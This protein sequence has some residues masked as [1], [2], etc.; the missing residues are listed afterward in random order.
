MSFEAAA[1]SGSSDGPYIPDAAECMRCGMCVSSC[2]TFRLFEIDEETPRR[3]IRSIGKVLLENQP[4]DVEEQAHLDN[5]LQ[6]RS[7]ETVCPSRMAYGNLF[8]QAQAKIKLD[9]PLN[10]QARLAFWLV[11]HK[12]WRNSLLPLLSLYLRSG[13]QRPL[14]AS[15]LLKKIKLATAEAMLNEPSLV[16]LSGIYP[17]SQ[18]K[19]RGRVALFTGCLAENFD[20]AT[21]RASIKLLNAIGYEVVVPEGQGCCGAIHQHNGQSAQK[22]IDNNIAVFYALEVE[23]VLYSAS[24]CGAMLT[25]Y[26]NQDAETAGWFHRH[27]QDVNQFLLQHWPE[28][29]QL[30]ASNLNVAVHEPCSQRNVLKNSQSVYALLRKIPGLNLEPLPDNQLCCGAGGSYLLTHPENA[31]QLRD[32]KRQAIEG[33]GADLVVSSNFSCALHLNVNQP[34][35][36]LKPL[37]PLQLLADRL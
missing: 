28:N 18:H 16:P 2:P 33:C 13:L 5:C 10:W 19:R 11:E 4:L 20:R 17:T 29:L 21:Q 26:G 24:G 34:D 37:H 14:R 32:L 31:G 1:S 27:L 12:R 9:Q 8:D 22:L 35:G 6:C 23:A 3:R 30:A 25:E 15:G 36:A 7:C